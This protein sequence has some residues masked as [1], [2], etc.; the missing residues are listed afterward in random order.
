MIQT[1]FGATAETEVAGKLVDFFHTLPSQCSMSL[2]G[3]PVAQTSD[4][5]VALTDV[6]AWESLMAT[7]DHTAPFHISVSPCVPD[8]SWYDPTA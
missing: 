2:A 6:K 7:I 3:T 1:S 4:G 5:E 8:A